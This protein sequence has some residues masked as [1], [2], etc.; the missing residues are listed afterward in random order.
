MQ[1]AVAFLEAL[2]R[3]GIL[4]QA[5]LGALACAPLPS[6]PKALAGDLL[7]RGRLTAFQAYLL[8]Q[9]RGDELLLG[10]YLLLE[11]LGE[12]GM[13]QV[14]K[15]RHLRG[16]P[17]GRHSPA[18]IRRPRRGRAA[19]GPGHRP[20]GL[21]PANGPRRHRD[22]TGLQPRRPDARRRG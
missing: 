5:E 22:R 21:P 10:P 6:E 11:R 19:V 17:P 4:E 7:R 14:F 18:G 8:L 9:E 16:L 15:A 2:R 12:G 1:T 20:P 3:L 13:G